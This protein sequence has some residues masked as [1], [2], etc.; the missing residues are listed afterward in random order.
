MSSEILEEWIT[1]DELKYRD[2]TENIHTHIACTCKYYGMYYLVIDLMIR[3]HK[4]QN[5][6]QMTTYFTEWLQYQT[7]SAGSYSIMQLLPYINVLKY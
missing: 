2:P 1:R 3:F 5:K 6:Y 7:Y 4:M